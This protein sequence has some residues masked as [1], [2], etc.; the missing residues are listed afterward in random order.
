M[1][2][3]MKDIILADRKLHGF[4]TDNTPTIIYQRLNEDE[5]PQIS[6]LIHEYLQ[7]YS[8][9]TLDELKLENSGFD[10]NTEGLIAIIQNILAAPITLKSLQDNQEKVRATAAAEAA[11]IFKNRP[12]SKLFFSFWMHHAQAAIANRENMR[13]CRARAFGEVK[14]LFAQIGKHMHTDGLI[15]QADDVF[16]LDMPQLVD[17]CLGKSTENLGAMV[18]SRKKQYGE[19]RKTSPPNRIMFQHNPPEA[20]EEQQE[21][22]E[23]KNQLVG[24]AVSAGIVRAEA[25]VVH[26][27]NAATEVKGRILVTKTTDP[28]WI[29]LMAQSAGIICEKGSLLSHAAIVSRELGIPTV[30]G[31]SHATRLIKSGSWIT[32]NG[33]TGKI[34]LETTTE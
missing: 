6:T 18:A 12:L 7:L 25:L 34:D 13:L 3:E 33:S 16:Y 10:V 28:G 15:Q 14:K 5:C 24:T 20:I 21:N 11:V 30:V 29:F 9:R 17:F 8:N 23:I 26:Q 22:L 19:F 2:L 1:L 4:F 27:P 31:V 32:L